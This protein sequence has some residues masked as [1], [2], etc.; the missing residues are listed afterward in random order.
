MAAGPA[1]WPAGG[2]VLAGRALPGGVADGC[3][4]EFQVLVIQAGD[5]VAKADGE[6]AG[7]AGGELEDTPFSP[8][9]RDLPAVQGAE[10]SVP[11][12]P[13][14]QRG[15]VADAGAGV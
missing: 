7:D 13:G 3:D 6:A 12:D 11:V 2:G 8:A 10:C 5:G 1:G 15:A 14:H 9:G 4:Q